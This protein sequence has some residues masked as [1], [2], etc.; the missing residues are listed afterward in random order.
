[1]IEGW[2]YEEKLEERKLCLSCIA[3]T[4]EGI[5][6]DVYNFCHDFVESGELDKYLPTKENLLRDEVKE[7]GNDYYEMMTDKVLTAWRKYKK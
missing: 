3:K 4:G 1:M 6:R 7:Y 2:G 5:N